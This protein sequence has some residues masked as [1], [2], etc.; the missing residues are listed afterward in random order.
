MR[1]SVAAI[2][3]EVRTNATVAQGISEGPFLSHMSRFITYCPGNGTRYELL[4]T[5]LDDLG[6][7]GAEQGFTLVTWKRTPEPWVAYPFKRMKTPHWSRIVEKLHTGI[8]DAI[9][10][11]EVIALVLKA[12]LPDIDKA[13]EQAFGD[14]EEE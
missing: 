6:V 1:N 9:A 13:I 11:S 10:L 4:F 14:P 12:E 2:R 5:V 3:P 7:A 8:S